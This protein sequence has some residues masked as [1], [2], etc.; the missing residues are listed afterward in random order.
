MKSTTH[1]PRLKT[2]FTLIELL[3]VIAIIAILAAMI[4]PALSSAK[5]RAMRT[6]CINNMRQTGMANRMYTDDNRDYL[7]PPNWQGS[8]AGWLYDDTG[9][10][11]DPGPGGAYETKPVQAYKSG[12]WFQYMQNPKSYLC[13]VDMKSPT[14]ATVGTHATDDNIRIN[15]FSSYVMDG[16]VCGYGGNRSCKISQAW[17]PL[18]Y[19]LWEPDENKNGPGSPGAFDFNDGSNYPDK[20]EGIGRLHSR[21]GGM[22]VTLM[23]NAQFL[24]VTE[25]DQDG[26]SSPGTGPGP[27]GKS[28]LWWSTFSSNGR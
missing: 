13:P 12:L 4:L 18:C 11:M 6:T 5:D 8:V 28:F 7:A 9:G 17:S 10:M 15:R 22:A 20:N 25:F 27:G 24:S 14:Y 26:G 3:V 19:L 21:K 1:C 2:A 16:A 23:G